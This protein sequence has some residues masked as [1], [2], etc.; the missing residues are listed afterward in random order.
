VLAVIGKFEPVA[1]RGVDAVLMAAERDLEQLAALEPAND[2]ARATL[3]DAGAPGNRSHTRPAFARVVGREV[4][5][6]EQHKRLGS[7]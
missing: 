1:A 4:R 7:R 3:V 2:A 6:R 5:E